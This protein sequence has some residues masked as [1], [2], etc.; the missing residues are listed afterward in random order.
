MRL[1]CC[2]YAATFIFG[3]SL[4]PVAGNNTSFADYSDGKYTLLS[5]SS[6]TKINQP[7]PTKNGLMNFRAQQAVG[8][9][10]DFILS[11]DMLFPNAPKNYNIKVNQEGV[12]GVKITKIMSQTQPSTVKGTD[13]SLQFNPRKLYSIDIKVEFEI[14][15]ENL[16]PEKPTKYSISGSPTPTVAQPIATRETSYYG[17]RL[18]NYS[19]TLPLC[20]ESGNNCIHPPGP[21]S[22]MSTSV[23]F[24]EGK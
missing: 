20:K 2:R 23:L 21:R 1:L 12:S 18:E 3:A 7:S 10:D 4:L 19:D 9:S 5:S 13:M 8:S 15:E 11:L 22:A 17:S 14:E 24:R 6:A 16:S